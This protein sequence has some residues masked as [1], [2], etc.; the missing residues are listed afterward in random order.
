LNSKEKG[1]IINFEQRNIIMKRKWLNLA[2]FGFCCL[3]AVQS[4][5]IFRSSPSLECHL[6]ELNK[7]PGTGYYD[8]V[9]RL[10]SVDFENAFKSRFHL[11]TPTLFFE[12]S[13]LNF[14]EE[15]LDPD[16]LEP[17]DTFVV[18]LQ[19]PDWIVSF[20]ENDTVLCVIDFWDRLP[21]ADQFHPTKTEAMEVAENIEIDFGSEFIKP[22]VK[23]LPPEWS[24]VAEE[25]PEPD[26]P[27]GSIQYQKLRADIIREEVFIQYT[28]M[29]VEEKDFLVLVSPAE[30]LMQWIEWAR[31]E[32]QAAVQAGRDIVFMDVTDPETLN[33]I[34]RYAYIDGDI[35]LDVTLLSDPLEWQKT[36]Q[37]KALERRTDKVFLW[38]GFDDGE[39]QVLIEVRMD[40]DGVYRKR[41]KS[42]ETIEKAFH[43]E[44]REFMDIERV[45][46][47]NRFTEL[48][49]RSGPPG[50][51]RSFLTVQFLDKTHSV[52]MKNVSE[53]HFKNIED[54]IRKVVLP[55]IAD[56]LN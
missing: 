24:F 44:E 29:T 2:T 6:V 25:L 46:Q 34:Y 17:G 42:G 10:D 53:P 38:Y 33:R 9:I 40:R 49:S 16:L 37:E 12:C 1:V 20:R 3:L 26:N 55:K 11:L 43:L 21:A 22:A 39:D 45:L 30:A 5:Q 7:K 56:F 47:E 51:I 23:R 54:L 19:R 28:Y 32:G 41:L 36:E 50:G 15:G 14:V 4:C 35:V 31:E 48:Q 52:E 13:E 27:Y 8:A 18:P